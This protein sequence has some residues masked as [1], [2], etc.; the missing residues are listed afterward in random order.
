MSPISDIFLRCHVEQTKEKKNQFIPKQSVNANNSTVL[1]FDTETSTD[2]PQNLTMGS[3]GVVIN[4]NLER[5][6]VFHEDGLDEQ[7][8]KIIRRF[9][10]K[11]KYEL[12]S[13]TD[14][15]DEIFYPYV[16]KGRAV[17]VGFN[18][19]FDISRLA[20]YFTESRKMKNGF[21]FTLS[22]NKQNPNI[23][24]KHNSKT[25]SFIEFTKPIRQKNQ[26]KKDHYK[27]CFVDLKTLAFVLTNKSYSLRNALKDFGC[28]LEK[29]TVSEHGKISEEYLRYNVKDTLA[30]YELYKKC[31][32]RYELYGLNKDPS[33][34]HS[35]ASIGKA[36]HEKMGIIPFSAKNPNF[37]KEILGQVMQTYYGGR[38][39]VGIRNEPVPVSY[40]DFTSMYPTVYSLL[41]M[42]KFL[43]AAKIV[44]KTSTEETKR[45]VEEITLED[46]SKTKT[47]KNL[48]TICKV[49]PDEDILPIRSKYGKKQTTNIG[50]NYLKSVD[51]TTVWYA[52]PDVISSKILT[53]K[54]PI[55]EE[56]IT[57]VPEEMQPGLKEIE[58]VKGISV[59]PEEDFI[60]TLIEKRIEIKQD[61]KQNKDNLSTQ[62]QNEL[63]INQNILKIIANSTSYG[64]FIEINPTIN[65]GHDKN[66]VTVY[67]MENFE[68]EVAKFEK[69]GKSFNPIMS[70]FLT[71]SSRL[72][73]A[74]A[75]KLVL[76]EGGHIAY[77]DTD[78]VFVSPQHVKTV[79]K[80]FA[81]L[82]PYSKH[83]EMFK[84][85]ENDDGVKLDNVLFF[86]IS[87]KRYV[88][89][90]RDIKTGKITI[91]KHSAHGLG[92]IRGIDEKQW[93]MDILNIHY[94]PEQKGEILSKYKTKYAI[95]QLTI[96]SYDILKRFSKLNKDKPLAQKIKPF[97][98][99]TI[100]TATQTDKDTG[101][102][103]IPML[104]YLDQ[105]N[106]DQAPFMPFID[107]KT[108]K[109]YPNR[110]N[111]LESHFYWKRQSEILEKYVE[112]NDEKS[113]GTTG[114]LSRKH[115]A[116]GKSSVRYIGKEANELE[117]SETIGVSDKNYSEYVDRQG[118]LVEIIDNLTLDTAQRIGIAKRT[119]FDLKKKA[120]SSVTINLKGKT[121]RKLRQLQFEYKQ[122][123]ICK[124]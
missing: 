70:V 48:T 124:L 56:A 123:V 104:P 59:R 84:V 112:H 24:I 61:L 85:E 57:F 121:L 87:A 94:H 5:F 6:I 120:S 96:S 101:E 80:F 113:E 69:P 74:A 13:R 18:L 60:K 100:G 42:D 88:L 95:S 46:I 36:Y 79:Q 119:F 51:D 35:P 11:N 7:R 98:F 114:R 30:T 97:N 117:E 108:G 19:S 1:V 103:I 4:G 90:Q 66:E 64:I 77:C 72:I 65:K 105:K 93:W 17:C 106:Q 26:K 34:L 8:L 91:L 49:K 23:V 122:E 25:S 75:E 55:I 32:E 99:I 92:H 53:K 58:I 41:S 50:L 29:D 37:P 12:L 111:L 47:W 2:K 22:E 44:P 14:F 118:K 16:Y 116:I 107:Y 31:L 9:C 89:F 45:L 10:T 78:S 67:G 76:D 82:N 33:L 62:E 115:I 81:R 40:I 102:P 86:G 109:S 54:T 63:K 110:E 83:V 52:L 43:K 38:T 71:A 3:C 20:T 68:T 28:K 39:G 15:V 73:L 21:S 27:G